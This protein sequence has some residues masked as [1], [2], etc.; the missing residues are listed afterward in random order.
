MKKRILALLL[1]GLMTAALASC[2][3]TGNSNDTD[4]GTEDS[5]TIESTTDNGNQNTVEWIKQEQTVYT[6]DSV[7]FRK[8][9][10]PTGETIS[11]L[12]AK[13]EL[14]S[15]RVSNTG[16]CEVEYDGT[17]GYVSAKYVTD[18]DIVGN[19]FTPVDGGEKTMYAN[20][21]SLS[22][23]LYPTTESFSTVKGH[24]NLNDPVIVVAT[25]DTWSRVK[26]SDGSLYYVNSKYLSD[27]KVVDINDESQYADK[28]T[29][30]A[31]PLT[32]YTKG[33]VNM[34]KVPHLK[35]DILETLNNAE[36]KVL[37]TGT[38]DGI[39]WCYV[40][41]LIPPT[42]EGDTPREEKGYISATYLSETSVNAVITLE[43][44]LANYAGFTKLAS[45]K[46]MYVLA[47]TASLYA[48]TSPVFEGTE[49]IADT[50]LSKQKISVVAT[51]KYDG[52]NCCIIEM[53][54]NEKKAYYFVG[55]SHLTTN[56]DGLPT[57]TLDDLT[58]KYP[59][60]TLCEKETVSATG[61]VNCYTIPENS[62]TPA[63][64][65]NT[66]DNVSLVA[67]QTGAYYNNWWVIQT[68]DGSLFFVY[69]SL[70]AS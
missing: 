37:K 54:K 5:Q 7:K 64:K 29:A 38:V 12:P 2:Q 49:N 17:I 4:G 20:T 16:W 44:V 9:A 69:K 23:R 55:S 66:G 39:D 43:D 11:T 19:S 70:F 25:N 28:F 65:L 56:V 34:R 67:K 58:I 52:V 62:K 13:T 61:V 10:S 47:T 35:G 15:K 42:K 46:D 27:T 1:A 57:V 8:T 51:G 18:V 14:Q 59:D 32:K 48:R 50:L 40:V 22:I 68:E 45:A 53:T 41:A 30:C 3:A 24:Y 60:F 36:V 21:T 63:H 31:E 26:T 6:T 33:Q